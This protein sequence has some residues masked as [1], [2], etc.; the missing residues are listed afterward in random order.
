[1]WVFG[2]VVDYMLLVFCIV[3]CMFICF[4]EFSGW[5]G[6]GMSICLVEVI[7]NVFLVFGWI[8]VMV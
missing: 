4:W 6:Y 8:M 2:L 3:M 7:L 5:F 1:M